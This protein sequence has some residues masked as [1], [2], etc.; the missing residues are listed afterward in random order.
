M[1]MREGGKTV[2]LADGGVSVRNLSKRGGR[3]EGGSMPRLKRTG[4]DG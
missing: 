1:L 2:R 4:F 3:T